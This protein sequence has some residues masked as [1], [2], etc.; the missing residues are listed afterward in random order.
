MT[1][2]D[3]DYRIWDA[4]M[5]IID[6]DLGN[7]S[8]TNDIENVVAEIQDRTKQS[9]MPVV[10]RDSLGEWSHYYPETDSFRDYKPKKDF[11]PNQLFN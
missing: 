10:Y 9:G 7:K 11:D 4:T 6:L 8:L 3:Y 5:Y 2:A 1:R